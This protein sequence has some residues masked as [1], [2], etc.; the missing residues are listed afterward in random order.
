MDLYF[1][2]SLL[3]I[4]VLIFTIV[5]ILLDTQT[6]SKSLAYILLVL[7]IPVAGI[8]FYFSFGV[9][10]RHR[11]Y[12]LEANSASLEVN[13]S[14]QEQ[15]V[16]TTDELLHSDS[17]IPH[18]FQSL[19]EFHHH[20]MGAYLSKNSFQLLINGEDKYPEVLRTLASAKR[21][22][23]MEYYAWEN[24]TRGNQIKDVLL[25]KIQEGVKIRILYDDYASRGIRKNIVKELQEA[26]VEIYPKIRLK[27]RQ[28]AN[29]LNH[30]DHRKVIIVDGKYGFVGGLNISDRYDNTIHTK[31]YWRDTH[32]K[33]TG[34]LVQELQKHFLSSWNAAQSEKLLFSG[35][36]LPSDH[37][38]DSLPH[39]GLAQIIPGGPY[40]SFSNIMLSYLKIFNLARQKLY[41][42]NP[43]FIPSSSILNALKQA[44]LSGVDVRLLLPEKSDS[45]LVG[46]ASR[47]YFDELLEA[48]VR[49]FL[50]TKGFIH[51][52]TVVAD[53]SLSV[54]GTANMDIRSFDLNFE[55]MSVVYGDDLA[56][57]LE[58][59]FMEDLKLSRE[60]DADFWNQKPFHKKLIYAIARVV[61]SFL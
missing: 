39:K 7:V 57:K 42:T 50:Y 28:F 29:R 33:F 54:V 23:H 9:N 15:I 35:E 36:F 61:S 16:D 3:Y 58:S 4:G 60:I 34:P 25:E 43:Y 38:A 1:Y 5:R 21:F 32:A 46:A 51:A 13:K 40:Y 53:G 56:Q 27:I 37:T 2:L 19:V 14:Y 18:H 41:V 52:K 48:G 20:T 17:K 45:S 8:I 12:N 55:I 26:G 49:I 22:I 11:S 10:Y 30:R 44:A 24:D 6:S 59:V 31:L 47:F